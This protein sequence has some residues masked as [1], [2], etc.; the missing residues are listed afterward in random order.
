MLLGRKTKPDK[1]YQFLSTGWSGKILWEGDMWADGSEWASPAVFWE[2]TLLHW[3]HGKCKG[4]EEEVYME[5][6]G[7]S[8]EARAARPEGQLREAADSGS[9]GAL[10]AAVSWEA[11]QW[12][13]QS[14][15][16]K[17]HSAAMLTELKTE[18]IKTYWN[19]VTKIVLP[20]KYIHLTNENF[21][22]IQ[23]TIY[24][25]CY[26]PLSILKIITSSES[27]TQNT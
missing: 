23:K 15:A 20:F 14:W 24:Y 4:P 7:R 17:A 18:C 12:W 11:R 26:L 25:N 21:F 8:Q 3:G 22:P 1:G 5:Y 2:E 6:S 9:H 19:K 13:S 27:N 10:E 16:Q